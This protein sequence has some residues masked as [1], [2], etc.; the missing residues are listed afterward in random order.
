MTL[1]DILRFNAA[2]DSL[3]WLR[4]Q[5]SSCPALLHTP[6]GASSGP[7][8]S[9]ECPMGQHQAF[10]DECHQRQWNLKENIFLVCLIKNT[11]KSDMPEHN[12]P[13]QYLKWKK[14]I[15]KSAYS[16]SK[17]IHTGV[18]YIR[19]MCGWRY[20]WHAGLKPFNKVGMSHANHSAVNLQWHSLHKQHNRL[21][22]FLDK[23][24]VDR[25]WHICSSCAVC[26]PLIKRERERWGIFRLFWANL[27]T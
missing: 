14:M 5:M 9:H 2:L 4:V 7:A 1:I 16:H 26:L 11:L 21:S 20:S 17:C 24:T 3:H 13:M 6:V 25:D 12:C 15:I 19:K 22:M 27:Y 10:Q 23:N 8:P 18:E